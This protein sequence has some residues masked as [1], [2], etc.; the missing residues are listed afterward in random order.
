MSRSKLVGVSSYHQRHH[1]V[2]L[3]KVVPSAKSEDRPI[4][5]PGRADPKLSTEERPTRLNI[6]IVEGRLTLGQG[7]TLSPT[8]YV[9]VA[10]SAM[11][12]I[13]PRQCLKWSPGV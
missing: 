6:A 2:L 4:H 12:A 9:T 13:V 11:L 7:Q 3:H 5:L 1:R 8:I 10:G